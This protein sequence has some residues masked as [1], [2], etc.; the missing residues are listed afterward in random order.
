M[1]YDGIHT[2]LWK[3][4]RLRSKYN[5]WLMHDKKSPGLG[6]KIHSMETGQG[7]VFTLQG[8]IAT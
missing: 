2:S 7:Q 4:L 1:I 8:H 6:L 3:L 5:V